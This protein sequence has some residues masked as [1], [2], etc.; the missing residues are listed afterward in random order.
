MKQLLTGVRI[1]KG[2]VQVRIMHKGRY[3]CKNFGADCDLAR[4]YANKHALEKRHEI[5]L[6]KFGVEPEIPSK[7]FKDAAA[8]WLKLWS[9]E[10][11][12]DGTLLHNENS[13]RETARVVEKVLLPCFSRQR[14]ESI[15]PIDV[16]T[17]RNALLR[18][19]ISGTSANRYQ[20]TL[21]SLFGSLI[22]WVKVEKI[23]AFKIPAENPCK[24][25]EKAP[26]VKRKRVLTINELKGLKAA[27]MEAQ[28]HDLW[29]ICEMA[30]KSLLR[31][32]DLFALEAGLDIDTTQAKTSRPIRLPVSV[33]R[34][35]RYGNFRKRW[36]AARKAA[37]LQ[38]VQFRDLRKTGLNLLKMRGHSLKLMSEFAGHADQ[39]TTEIYMVKDT[40]HLKPLADDLSNVLASL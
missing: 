17:W 7:L 6:G 39:K 5:R 4:E 22:R 32:K 3:Y 28:D 25:V 30:I 33:L 27:C 15:R 16:E 11:N 1:D 24:P 10:T 20:A 13:V 31:K 37:R 34:P 8:I 19:G 26:N 18:T 23:S 14:V 2:Y 35:L 21:S 38:D 12:P 36:E 29:E 40:D 9:E